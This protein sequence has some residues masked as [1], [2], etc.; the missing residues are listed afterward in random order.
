[1]AFKGTHRLSSKGITYISYNFDTA[2][3]LRIEDPHRHVCDSAYKQIL[4]RHILAQHI[5]SSIIGSA[6]KN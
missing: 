6:E 5:K 1:M 3:Y 4:F 2:I